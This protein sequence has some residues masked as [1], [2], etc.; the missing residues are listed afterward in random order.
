MK[1]R[2]SGLGMK[3]YPLLPSSYNTTSS[4]SSTMSCS[5]LVLH[6]WPM[7]S[8]LICQTLLKLPPTYNHVI[9]SAKACMTIPPQTLPISC[10]TT[11]HV[12]FESKGVYDPSSNSPHIRQPSFFSGSPLYSALEAALEADF[13]FQGYDIPHVS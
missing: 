6:S 5:L 3:L 7:H 8:L 12:C 1:C 10:S 4:F 2:E 11:Y 13:F 9:L